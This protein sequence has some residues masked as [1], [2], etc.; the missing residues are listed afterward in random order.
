[1]SI[2]DMCMRENLRYLE[3]GISY[4]GYTEGEVDEERS[5][6]KWDG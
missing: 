3:K 1:M 2:E 4:W 5:E 6:R